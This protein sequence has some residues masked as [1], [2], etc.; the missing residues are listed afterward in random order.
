MNGSFMSSSC[1][2]VFKPFPTMPTWIRSLPCMN[3]HV[4]LQIINA[5]THFS[6]YITSGILL[7]WN[8][9]PHMG[10]LKS[11]LV[12]EIWFHLKPVISLSI[13]ENLIWFCHETMHWV[14]HIALFTFLTKHLLLFHLYN[15]KN[16]K[17][18]KCFSPI[19]SQIF[20]GLS[21]NP[22]IR[23]LPNN[24]PPLTFHITFK[25]YIFWQG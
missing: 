10:R 5:S 17:I 4:F 7:R 15:V 20:K 21:I 13:T 19:N 1:T 22:V 2:L 9:L 18:I 6:T 25:K 16:K 14:F 8:L 24:H 23:Y 3:P 12:Q 11:Y